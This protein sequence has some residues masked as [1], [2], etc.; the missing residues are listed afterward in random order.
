MKLHQGNLVSKYQV[1][2]G[3]VLRWESPD[4]RPVKRGQRFTVGIHLTQQTALAAFVWAFAK[5]VRHLRRKTRVTSNYLSRACLNVVA[6]AG[7]KG[8]RCQAL[9][10]LSSVPCGMCPVPVRLLTFPTPSATKI[11]PA[12]ASPSMVLSLVIARAGDVCTPSV[13]LAG[14]FRCT[15]II[16]DVVVVVMRA[17]KTRQA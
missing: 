11:S 13:L 6:F 17:P 14:S 3:Q 10:F 4:R 16:V 12:P 8:A 9:V 1:S 15:R 2:L 5:P 7:H